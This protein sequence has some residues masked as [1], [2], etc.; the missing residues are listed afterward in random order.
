MIAM[1][2]VMQMVGTEEQP[3]ETGETF[4]SPGKVA[5][6]IEHW[7]ELQELALLT[8]QSPSRYRELTNHCTG[9]NLEHD[10]MHYLHTICDLQIARVKLEPAS[11]EAWAVEAAMHNV[12]FREAE[13]DHH[14]R[15]CSLLEAFPRACRQMAE[16][17]GWRQST[18]L[19]TRGAI[20]RTLDHDL[21]ESQS[22]GASS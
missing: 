21:L 15:H 9:P 22:A 6:W 4:Y 3:R 10:R 5:Y 11:P 13:H 8:P 2:G 20:R 18:R 14:I 12:T 17:L 7:G 1:A 19:L 16:S